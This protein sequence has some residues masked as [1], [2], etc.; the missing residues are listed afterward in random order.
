MK[1]HE[2]VTLMGGQHWATD[3][4][5]EEHDILFELLIKL[6]MPEILAPSGTRSEGSSRLLRFQCSNGTYFI[7]T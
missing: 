3:N 7:V 4:K 6:S 2:Q 5:V 1:S